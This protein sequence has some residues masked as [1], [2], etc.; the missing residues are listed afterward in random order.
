M[1]HRV[2]ISPKS[3]TELYDAALWWAENRDG[4][5]ASRWPDGF[6]AALTLLADDPGQHPL[7]SEDDRFGITL[8]QVLY[9]VGQRKTH[10]AVFE[11]RGEVV[12]VHAIRHLAQRDLSPDDL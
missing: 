2:R 11:I 8:H 12:L 3:K 7:A 10:R 1:A 6:E 9:G 4:R 5:Q